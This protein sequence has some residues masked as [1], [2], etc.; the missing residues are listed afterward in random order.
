M[1]EETLEE[2]TFKIKSKPKQLSKKR[3]PIKVD[4][5]KPKKEK[6]AIQV[7]ETK[8]GGCGRTNRRWQKVDE[9]EYRVQPDCLNVEE[10]P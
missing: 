7:G 10:Q 5:S 1:S 8:T 9:A 3:K 2:G 6:D 4:L